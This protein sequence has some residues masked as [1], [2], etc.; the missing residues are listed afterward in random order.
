[1]S[2]VPLLTDYFKSG[3][4]L[5][6]LNKENP[7]G[8]KGE[9]ALAYAELVNEIWSG[10]NSYTTPRQFKVKPICVDWPVLSL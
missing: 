7:L 8:R 9:L 6:E 10:N 2:N 1:M 5:K 4:H 3:R